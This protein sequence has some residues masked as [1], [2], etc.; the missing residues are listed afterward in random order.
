MKD[1][2]EVDDAQLRALAR[3]LGARGAERLDVAKT[4]AAVVARL[5]EEPRAGARRW[6][7]IEPAWAR[8][9]A[10]AAAL[11]LLIGAGFVARGVWWRP[12]SGVTALAEPSG[13]DM[14]DLSVGQL[15]ELLREVGQ[16]DDRAAV[17]A[18]DASID[19]LSAP[20]LRALLEELKG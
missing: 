4:A 5:R 17:S 15:E 19:E 3:E 20:Q 8:V 6:T 1:Y 18:Q 9:T 14:S 7:W 16:P 11:V 13:A 2:E 10:A 12:L